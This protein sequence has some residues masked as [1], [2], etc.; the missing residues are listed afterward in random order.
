V[1]NK[2]VPEIRFS[3]FTGK[4]KRRKLGEISEKVTGKNKDNDYSETLTNSAEF[5]IIT[6]RD[7]FEKDISNKKN[8]N[9]YYIVHPDYF[10]YNP[11]ISNFAPVGPIKRNK[12]ERTGVMSPL[13]YVFQTHDVDKTYLEYYFLGNNWHR[14]MKLNGDSGARSDRF[15]IKDSV[16]REMPIPIPSGEEQTTIG[17]FFK[18]LDDT[19]AIHE[20]ELTNLKQTKHGFLRKMFPKKGESVPEIRFPGFVGDWEQCKLSDITDSIGTGKSLF[21]KHEK[22]ADNPYAILGSTSIIGYD[23]D[24]DHKGDFILTARVGANA[25]NLY[26]YYGKAKITDNTVFIKGENLSFLYPLLNHF[27]LKKLSFGT[28]QPLIKASELKNLQIKSPSFEEQTKI[29]NFF[30]QLDDTIA[31]HEQELETLKE[32]KKAFL[33]KMFV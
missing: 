31:L 17:N 13:Y 12:L 7:F 16:F 22:S 20:Q 10:V 5:G 30:K 32:T 23:S 18:Q 25:G 21:I 4:W 15:A 19:I 27:D 28:G 33:Q 29:G 11:R 9:G 6:Q 26:R 8:L 24:F 1:G 2:R 3:Q 14:F